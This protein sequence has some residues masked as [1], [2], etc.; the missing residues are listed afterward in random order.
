M[1]FLF[2]SPRFFRLRLPVV[3]E[4]SYGGIEYR[5]EF[6]RIQNMKEAYRTIS[7]GS[8][9][10]HVDGYDFPMQFWVQAVAHGLRIVELQREDLPS[11]GRLLSLLR[12]ARQR[13]ILYC[14]D[15]SFGHDD[16]HYKSLKAVLDGG[17]E[18]RGQ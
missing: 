4:E 5:D 12:G 11:V 3:Y 8:L 2:A 14:D 1:T 9:P 16:A 6:G 17:I 13:F 7:C 18:G 15:L 10:L